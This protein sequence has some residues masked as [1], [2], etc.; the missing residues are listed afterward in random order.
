[1][2]IINIRVVN[3]D[4]I[5]MCGQNNLA[6]MDKRFRRSQYYI[7]AEPFDLISLCIFGDMAQLLSVVYHAFYINKQHATAICLWMI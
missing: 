7:K 6:I 4:E 1:M 5:S 2:S 3:C